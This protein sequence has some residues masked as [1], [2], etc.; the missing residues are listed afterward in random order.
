[1]KRTTEI[2]QRKGQPIVD[3]ATASERDEKQKKLAALRLPQQQKLI[4]AAPTPFTWSL[5]DDRD[6]QELVPA[7]AKVNTEPLA[8]LARG[9]T[10][11]RN[12]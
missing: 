2:E 11:Y 7:R 8:S 1:M 10:L 5:P 4:E 3:N 12:I 9:S 6:R